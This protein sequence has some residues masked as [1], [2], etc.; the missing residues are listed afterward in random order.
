MKEIAYIGKWGFQPAEDG[1][2]I[3]A[4]EVTDGV[5]HRIGRYCPQIHVGY[6]VIEPEKKILYCVDE[7]RN[8]PEFVRGGGG[9][10]YAL[11]I[12]EDGSLTEIN[13]QFSFGNLT[14]Y[15]A[16][17]TKK[18][19]LIVTNHGGGD[20][21]L[22]TVKDDE[23][24]YQIIITESVSSTVLYPLAEDGS[25]LPPVDIYDHNLHRGEEE[26]RVPH[27][28]SVVKAPGKDLFAV[29]DKG[30]DRVYLF[31]IQEDRLIVNAVHEGVHGSAP[32]YGCFHPYLPYFYYNEELKPYL[33]VLKYD[34]RSLDLVQR[35]P[36]MSEAEMEKN[37][38]SA[39]DLSITSDGKHLYHVQRFSNLISVFDVDKQ[40][41]LSLK[42]EMHFEGT[43]KRGEGARCLRLSPDEKHLYVCVV[44]DGKVWRYPILEDGTLAQCT[45]TIQTAYAANINF[46]G[47]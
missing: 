1:Y 21:V 24:N 39:S 23:G 28:H 7:N 6:A 27:L 9:K 22:Q 17:S 10:V 44:A 19:Y 37:G 46:F 38:A 33:N 31:G 29:C 18:D 45:D 47:V 20:P 16:L 35:T 15:C 11:K 32:R 41:L 43:D 25:I 26:T 8:Q 36:S 14:S 42:Q 34:D 2:G 5:F 13:H 3:E 4:Y 40:G 30:N 12:Q